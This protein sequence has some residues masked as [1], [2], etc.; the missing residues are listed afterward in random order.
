MRAVSA[1]RR[2]GSR[3]RRP[4]PVRAGRSSRADVLSRRAASR[5]ASRVRSSRRLSNGDAIGRYGPS[6]PDCVGAEA[7]FG[8]GQARSASSTAAVGFATAAAAPALLVELLRVAVPVAAVPVAVP[9]PC[10]SRRPATP[11]PR[12]RAS[13]VGAVASSRRSSASIG[14][15]TTFSRVTTRMPSACADSVIASPTRRS[16]RRVDD[17]E[18]VAARA[19]GRGSRRAA[20]VPT[21]SP[22]S[23]GR[24]PDDE[25]VE[26]A[27][28]ACVPVRLCVA[29]RCARARRWPGRSGAAPSRARR[30]RAPRR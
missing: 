23:G 4:R 21:N 16:G 14:R 12:S 29:L 17:H 27:Q 10:R 13:R 1:R 6:T 30:S 3:R 2:A 9:V 11:S 26:R 15:R 25:H 28:I 20:G 7:L 18:V 8:A 24:G 5:A 22:G 19:A